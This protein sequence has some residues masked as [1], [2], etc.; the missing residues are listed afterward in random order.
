MP[1]SRVQPQRHVLAQP[2]VVVLQRQHVIRARLVGLVGDGLLATHGVDAD[3]GPLQFQQVQHLRDGGDLVGLA[4][5]R[6]L[7]QHQPRLGGVGAQQMRRALLAPAS[8][9]GLAVQADLLAREAGQGRPRPAQERRREDPRPQPADGIAERVMRGDAVGEFQELPEPSLLF[10][11]EGF[12]PHP[13]FD[14]AQH[15]AEDDHQNILERVQ[16][17]LGG[18][19]WVGK[20]GKAG[21]GIGQHAGRTQ[22]RHRNASD[23]QGLDSAIALPGHPQDLT[24][25]RYEGK[26]CPGA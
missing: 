7:R 21:P 14:A 11:G 24:T 26:V 10:A 12:R 17:V 19:P 25:A 20:L 1:A 5:H 3:H 9:Q 16:L 15:R 2:R 4:V 18:P 23:C 8:A 6:L 22:S 13:V